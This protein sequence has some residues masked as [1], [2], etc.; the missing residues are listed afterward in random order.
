MLGIFRPPNADI[1]KA[2]DIVS[3]LLHGMNLKNPIAIVR[4][5]NI[6]NFQVNNSKNVKFKDFYSQTTTNITKTSRLCLHNPG[7]ELSGSQSTN[8]WAV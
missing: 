8:I 1:D 5:V 2:V 6:D 4:D 7:R 3:Q